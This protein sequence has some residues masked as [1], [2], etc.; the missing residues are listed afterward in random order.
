MALTI[1]PIRIYRQL[2]T[3]NNYHNSY[4]IIGPIKMQYWSIAHTTLQVGIE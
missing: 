2:K 1:T 4:N 3:N